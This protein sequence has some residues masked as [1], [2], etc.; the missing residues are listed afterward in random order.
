M[1]RK[2]KG[3]PK[4]RVDILCLKYFPNC[5]THTHTHIMHIYKRISLFPR[6]ALIVK[7]SKTSSRSPGIFLSCAVRT[8]STGPLVRLLFVKQT[9]TQT[10]YCAL[11]QLGQTLPLISAPSP[12]GGVCLC[13]NTDAAASF[14][15]Q[16]R[17]TGSHE[18]HS[19]KTMTW[20]D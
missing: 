3:S 12:R 17:W 6:E 7:F 5:T 9:H 14:H 19:C 8:H 1:G 10:N 4:P 2:P 11:S 13:V 15:L 18:G 20:E 16:G